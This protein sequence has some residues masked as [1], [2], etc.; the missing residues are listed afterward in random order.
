MLFQVYKGSTTYMGTDSVSAIPFDSL[1]SMQKAGYKFRL[2]GKTA[3]IS[4]VMELKKDVK[5]ASVSALSATTDVHPN[6]PMSVNLVTEKAAVRVTGTDGKVGLEV[7]E[8]VDARP[9]KESQKP[10][11]TPTPTS[12]P[13]KKRATK[14]VFCEQTGITYSSMSEAGRALSIDPAAVS[15]AAQTGRPTKGYTFKVIEPK[16]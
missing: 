3:S 12:A 11:P 16:E 1:S 6:A 15:Y 13:K 9:S 10:T 2:N 7:G 14:Q 8:F 4:T 5:R